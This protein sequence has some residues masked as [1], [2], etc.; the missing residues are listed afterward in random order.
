[1]YAGFALKKAQILEKAI[2]YFGL[3]KFN[4]INFG[5]MMCEKTS[6]FF[7]FEIVYLY[8]LFLKKNGLWVFKIRLNL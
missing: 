4:F 2:N 3:K 6:I 7:K 5:V 8:G 1:M